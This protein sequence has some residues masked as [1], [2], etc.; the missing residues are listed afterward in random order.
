[1]KQPRAETN[2]VSHNFPAYF[3]SDARPVCARFVKSNLCSAFGNLARPI[4]HLRTFSGKVFAF[5]A[6]AMAA[7]SAPLR[8]IARRELDVYHPDARNPKYSIYSLID[9]LECGHVQN[10]YLFGGLNDLMNAYT[11]NPAIKAKRHR[12]RPCASL[13]L[14]KPV[15]SVAIGKPAVAA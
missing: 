4:A 12:C 11:D 6:W 5:W 2:R 3:L 14:K 9:T 8:K 7:L 10:V 13:L 15:Q 1:M